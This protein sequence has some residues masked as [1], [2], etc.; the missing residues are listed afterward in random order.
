MESKKYILGFNHGYLLMK[1]K[2]EL[3]DF[4]V[5][6]DSKGDYIDGMKDGQREAFMEVL[7]SDLKK[8]SKKE[9]LDQEHK[10]R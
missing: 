5:E 6:N 1:E 3:V 9:V 2:P 4:L 10:K 8:K 7:S